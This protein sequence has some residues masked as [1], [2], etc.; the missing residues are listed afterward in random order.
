[1]T[2]KTIVEREMVPK[3]AEIKDLRE[4]EVAGETTI[5]DEVIGAIAGV[6][7]PRG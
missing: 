4:I 2:E 7:A 3:M 5:H 1:M 6:A